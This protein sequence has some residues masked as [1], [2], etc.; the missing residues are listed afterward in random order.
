MRPSFN[1]A[2]PCLPGRHY[3]LPPERRLGRVLRLIDDH[4]FFT[5][6]AGRQTGKTTSLMWL[7]DHLN[8]SGAWRA[9]WV[10]LETARE[11]DD[12]ARVM[13]VVLTNLDRVL[14]MRQPTWPRPDR[15]E[16][17]RLLDVPDSALLVYLSRLAAADPRPLVMLLDEADGLVGKAM[18]SVLTQL[19]QGY[20]E[21][22]RMP[23][24]ASV[25]LVGQRQVRDY[26]LRDEDRHAIAWLG[27]TSPFN[28]AAESLTLAAFSEDE[29]G[30][31]LQQ[32]T[33]ATGQAFAPEAVARVHALGQGHAVDEHVALEHELGQRAR[34]GPAAIG[35]GAG[36]GLAGVDEGVGA[37]PA[38]LVEGVAGAA[39]EHEHAAVGGEGGGD[40]VEGLAACVEQRQRL[41]LPGHVGDVGVGGAGLGHPDLGGLHGEGG[42]GV[43]VGAGVDEHAVGRAGAVGVGREGVGL[44]HEG[45]GAQ[46]RGAGHARRERGRGHGERGAGGLDPL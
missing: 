39:L 4:L 35:A 11:Q 32:H 36:V 27:T 8:A 17:A 33:T 42:Q 21:R 19:R 3:M 24:P 23:F 7:E 37:Q 28:I 45:V 13:K 12:V 2:G 29:V 14:S 31:L 30:E 38:L 34:G 43:V 44:G 16:L 1:V 46:G 9:V 22:S 41:A 18:V 40:A 5:L 26:V 15:A 10:D 20:I 6:H 25:A